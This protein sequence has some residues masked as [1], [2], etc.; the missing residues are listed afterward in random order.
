M[1][2]ICGKDA[3]LDWDIINRATDDGLRNNRRSSDRGDN[4]EDDAG[5]NR[6]GHK[7]DNSN[8][9]N[10]NSGNDSR[11]HSS[12]RRP[13]RGKYPAPNNSTTSIMPRLFARNERYIWHRLESF[14]IL[15]SK[16]ITGG[17][18]HFARV[19]RSVQFQEHL[20]RHQG[21]VAI[22]RVSKIVLNL[23]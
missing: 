1:V 22:F 6:H 13:S 18:I 7:S 15:L 10:H 9:G 5:G 21:T 23:R 4:E 14:E 3:K 16:P 12:A 17:D 2:E 8:D 19:E 11:S 20:N